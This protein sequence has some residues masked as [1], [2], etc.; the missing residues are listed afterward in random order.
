MGQEFPNF[1]GGTAVIGS[2]HHLSKPVLIGARTV[3]RRHGAARADFLGRPPSTLRRP[4]PVLLLI[5]G[6]ASALETRL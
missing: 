4:L 5:A 2:S 6:P 1:I 3:P